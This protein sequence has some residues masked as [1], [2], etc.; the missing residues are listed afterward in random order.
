MLTVMNLLCKRY[1]RIA[2]LT[3]NLAKPIIAH[4]S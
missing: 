2:L 3:Y 1:D 4:N